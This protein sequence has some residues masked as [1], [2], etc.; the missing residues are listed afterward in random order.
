M[1]YQIIPV[2]PFQQNCSLVWCDETMKAAVIDPGGDIDRILSEVKKLGVSLEKV[3]LTHGHID[4]VGGAKQLSEQLNIPIIGPHKADIFW[5]DNLVEQSQHFGL[6][7]CEP[8]T[9]TQYLEDGDS[10]TIGNL[11]L[12]VLHCPG[13]TPGHVVFFCEKAKTAWVGDV[14]FHGSVGRTDFPQSNHDDLILSITKKLWPLGRDVE[15]IPGHGPI[16]TFGS[17]RDQNPFVA[18]QL[19][20]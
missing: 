10:V 14:L 8:F 16:S 15:F 11:T 19:F 9:S 6:K 2:T 7:A 3:F 5:L 18:D 20:G 1:K 13:H 4:H 12:Q 17:E